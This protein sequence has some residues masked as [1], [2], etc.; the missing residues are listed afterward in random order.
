LKKANL[1]IVGM[2]TFLVVL[3]PILFVNTYFLA[4]RVV[5][6]ET[7]LEVF[8]NLTQYENVIFSSD[9]AHVMWMTLNYGTYE[10]V[11]DVNFGDSEWLQ[12]ATS[13]GGNRES[14]IFLKFPLS[15]I[16]DLNIVSVKLFLYKTSRHASGWVSVGNI[17]ARIV[18]NDSWTEDTI[19]WNNQPEYTTLLDVIQ[20]TFE[21]NRWYSWDVTPLV[22]HDYVSGDE[23]V[24]ICLKAENENQGDLYRSTDFRSSENGFHPYLSVEYE[25]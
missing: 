7:R 18:S 10:D 4:T 19:T 23:Y 9:D 3:T 21:S 17:E 14:R 5:S 12:V 15:S 6:F 1:L 2:L 24:S 11:S 13:V 8:E 22:Q 20:V 25:G 16:L